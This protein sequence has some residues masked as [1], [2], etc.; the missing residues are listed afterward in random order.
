MVCQNFHQAHLQKVGLAQIPTNHVSGTSI[1]MRIMGF[2]KLHG[3][4]PWL[5]CV[6]AP[7]PKP[8]QGPLHTQA[9]SR[10]R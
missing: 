10:D 3:H 9:K 7:S 1:W 8:E 2:H 4:M 5:M 6:V